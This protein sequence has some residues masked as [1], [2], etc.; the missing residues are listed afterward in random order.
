[1]VKN[2]LDKPTNYFLAGPSCESDKRKSAESIQQK[3][4]EFE[5]IFNGIGCFEGTYSLQLKPNS[6]PYQAL[7]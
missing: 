3:Y 1:M 6:K 7:P 4:K 5:D 2:N